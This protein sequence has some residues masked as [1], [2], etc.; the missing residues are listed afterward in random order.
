M[1]AT[2]NEQIQALRALPENWDGYGAASP[3]WDIL[4]AVGEFLQPLRHGSGYTDPDIAPTRIGGVLLSWEHGPH[5]LDV[6]FD[7]PENAEF[8]YLNR[9]TDESAT[10]VLTLP[11]ISLAPRFAFSAILSSMP[12]LAST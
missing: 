6:E 9:E 7:S 4:A 8:A 2:P 11:P 10:G 5:R 1:M 12:T 3:R